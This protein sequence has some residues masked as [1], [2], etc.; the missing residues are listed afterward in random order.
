MS[1][2]RS[3]KGSLKPGSKRTYSGELVG[4]SLKLQSPVGSP[5]EA[6]LDGLALICYVFRIGLPVSLFKVCTTRFHI[7][8]ILGSTIC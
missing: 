3:L 7:S 4:G 1:L 5:A 2:G 6:Q 8:F